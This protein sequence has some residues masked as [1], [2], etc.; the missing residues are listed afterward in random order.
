MSA[1]GTPGVISPWLATHLLNHGFGGGPAMTQPTALFV[2]LF[3]STLGA[4]TEIAAAD[5]VRQRVAFGAA[6]G[7][8]VVVNNTADIQWASAQ[9]AW[10]SIVAGGIFDALTA[11]NFFGWG[12]LLDATGAVTTVPINLGDTF[13]IIAGQLVVGIT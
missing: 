9:S 11:G 12:N 6:A 1:G 10:G 13:R 3:T 8:P 2:G 7:T 4:G 5:Y